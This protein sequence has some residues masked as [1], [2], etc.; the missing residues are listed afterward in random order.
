MR[1]DTSEK[2]K[3]LT[4]FFTVGLLLS[5]T[6]S[7]AV[8]MNQADAKWEK[9]GSVTLREDAK[10]GGMELLVKYPAGHVFKPHWHDSNERIVLIGGQLS[11]KVGESAKVLDPG[12]YAFLP[13]RELQAMSCVSKNPC[14]F[15]VSW[16]GSVKS[17]PAPAPAN[18]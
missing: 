12:G 5:Q 13:A 14:S 9:D 2:M 3:L 4:G 7:G 11:I 16:D 17:H 15:Y 6:E 10:T 8:H 1:Y 18:P